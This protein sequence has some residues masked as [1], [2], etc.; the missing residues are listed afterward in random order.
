MGGNKTVRAIGASGL[1]LRR[2]DSELDGLPHPTTARHPREGRRPGAERR[3]ASASRLP[4][5][6]IPAKRRSRASRDP[7]RHA[8]TYHRGRSPLRGVRD[9]TRPARVFPTWVETR[10]REQ[11]AHL[12]SAFAGVTVSRTG[13]PHP[14]TAT[15]S[16]RR[17]KAGSRAQACLRKSP[18]TSCHPGQAAQPREPGPRATRA[19]LSSRPWVPDRRCAASGMTVKAD[20]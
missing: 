10:P 2:S 8:Q 19:N 5:P 17:P 1:C 20:A 3:H 9:D 12:D 18:S 11:S 7:G 16:P 6:V 15:S 4:P 13:L 14:T